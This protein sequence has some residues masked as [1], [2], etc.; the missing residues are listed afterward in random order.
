MAT[1]WNTINSVSTWKKP[2]V[3]C[4]NKH[5][6]RLP[7]KV[8]ESPSL[9]AGQ[10]SNGHSP[11]EVALAG[12]VLKNGNWVADFH[13]SLP[14]TSAIV[15]YIWMNPKT[16]WTYHALLSH[17]DTEIQEGYKI[18]IQDDRG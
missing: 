11:E 18:I 15:T 12:P 3:Y 14:I 8:V 4:K 9:E 2:P 17:T 13:S 7:E 16:A 10:K 6:K 5:W 1:N